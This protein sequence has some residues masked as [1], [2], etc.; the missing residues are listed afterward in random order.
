MHIAGRTLDTR[1][2]AVDRLAQRRAQAIDVDVG[3]RE[4]VPDRAALLIQ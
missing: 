2:Q 1:R 4:Q 3:L